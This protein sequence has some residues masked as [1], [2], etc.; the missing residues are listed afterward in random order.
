MEFYTIVYTYYDPLP[1]SLDAKCLGV[2][3]SKKQALQ[4]L[5]ELHDGCVIDCEPIED[6]YSDEN[7]DNFTM[8][9]QDGFM[10]YAA[11][12]KREVK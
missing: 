10:C 8:K 4:A 5:R 2:Y 12:E 9:S 3:P 1:E 7:Y 11:V 6:N